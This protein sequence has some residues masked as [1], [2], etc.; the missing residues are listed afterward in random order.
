MLGIYKDALLRFFEQLEWSGRPIPL[1][2]A[3]AH[4]AHSQ[5]REWLA[6]NRNF[7][8]PLSAGEVAMPYPFGAITKAPFLEDP[9]RAS[10]G[11]YRIKSTNRE[12]DHGFVMRVPKDVTSDVDLNLYFDNEIQIDYVVMQ[13]HNIFHNGNGWVTIDFSDPEWYQGPHKQF[14]YAKMLGEVTLQIDLNDIT[15]S[16]STEEAG[17]N[18]SEFKYTV[19]CTLH[20]FIPLQPR[21]VPF[22]KGLTIDLVDQNTEEKLATVEYEEE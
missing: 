3:P 17:L 15:D 18:E 8:T 4:R 6:E 5:I 21:A 10:L 19:G 9:D 22:A 11:H 16:T 14:E 2:F 20:G 13:L 7:H 1:V 12:V